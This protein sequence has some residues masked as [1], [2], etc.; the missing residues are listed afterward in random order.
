MIIPNQKELYTL[1]DEVT[2]LNCASLSPLLRSVEEAGTWGLYERRHPWEIAAAQWFEPVETLRELFARIIRADRDNVALVPAVSYGIAV[3]AKN[4]P[5]T[6]HQTI[7]VLD[8]QYPSNVY[9]WRERSYET[10]AAIV[11]V[12][13][14]P[15]QSWTDAIL[16][17]IDERTG[18]VAIPNCHWTDGSLIDLEIVSRRAKDVKARLVVDASQSVGAYPLDVNAVRP[19]FLVS[20]GYKW[21]M[22]PYGLGYLYASPEFGER[23]V[24]LEYSW[25]N[26]SGAED[27]TRL[28]DYRDDYKTGARRFDAGESPSFIHVPMAIAALQQ[29]LEWGV[30]NIHETLSQRT[31]QIRT[32]ARQHGFTVS[33]ADAPNVGHIVGLD[34][35]FDQIPA[36]GRKLADHQV[37]VGFR[38]EKMRIAPYLYNS[39]DDVDRLFEALL[40]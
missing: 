25:L 34:F 8:Q 38:G 10:G 6:K 32:R 11:T 27:F 21:L 13:R 31:A 26:K 3:A 36:L 2:Y 1:P 24:P 33:S 22:G 4:I 16:A 28:A 35:T 30:A 20:V 19:D 29:I 17:H 40:Q 7:V 9:A 15:G 12:N 39:A 18:V 37:Y 5:L 14:Q 23:G